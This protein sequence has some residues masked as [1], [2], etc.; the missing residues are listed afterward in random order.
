MHTKTAPSAGVALVAI[1]LTVLGLVGL[2]AVSSARAFCGFY[3]GSAD[4]DLSSNATRVVL[5]REGTRTVLSMQ[6]DYEGPVEDFALVV[7]VPTVLREGDVHTLP[8]ALFDHVD[9]LSAPRLVEY[10]EQDPCPV[11]SRHAS[12]E[13]LLE[14]ALAR[15]GR[16]PSAGGGGGGGSHVHVEAQFV[17]G[18]YEIVILS[19]D[20]SVAL[21]AWLNDEGYRIPRGAHDALRP[22]VESGMKFFVARVD[23]ARVRFDN[24]RT[25]LS[26]LCVEYEAAELALPIRLG[27]LSSQGTQD[28]LVHVLSPEGR[29]E[30]AN[31]PNTTIPTNLRV[32]PRTAGDFG[33][34]YERMFE[35]AIREAPG[36]VVTEYAWS[37]GSCDPC[38]TPALGPGELVTLGARPSAG[39][40]YSTLPDYTLT[41]LH[42]RYTAADA[43]T[44]LVFRH[45]P[46]LEGGVGVPDP[47]GRLERRPRSAASFR[48]STFQGRYVILHRW[49]GPIACEA[50]RRGVWGGPNR[51]APRVLGTRSQAML[52]GRVAIAGAVRRGGGSGPGRRSTARPREAALPGPGRARPILRRAP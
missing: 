11:P 26:L 13:D 34:F 35:R 7:P 8:S 15:G 4:A 32:L 21:E 39:H 40:G 33:P 42:Y 41:R 1:G 20:E 22:Y 23:P 16:R 24:G 18:E 19:A 48:A 12:I 46:S 49:E 51:S 43:T 17:V 2:G 3:V 52:L 47:I 27:R 30:V 28:L 38:P 45:A 31:R 9:Q 50:P 14:G 10:W 44:D 5:L 36:A 6:N 37:S 29:F 25:V